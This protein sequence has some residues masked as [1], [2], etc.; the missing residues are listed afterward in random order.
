MPIRL[1]TDG[2]SDPNAGG[3]LASGQA[4][5][6]G[7]L[8]KASNQASTPGLDDTRISI[9][10]G[11]LSL[12]F[13]PGTTPPWVSPM[14]TGRS[15]NPPSP[16]CLDGKKY[17]SSGERSYPSSSLD[18]VSHISP[19]DRSSNGGEAHATSNVSATAET[20]AE[21]TKSS[22]WNPKVDSD[23]SNGSSRPYT[24]STV[25]NETNR[26]PRRRRLLSTT[27]H[28]TWVSSLRPQP[29]LEYATLPVWAAALLVASAF[30]VTGLVWGRLIYFASMGH[31]QDEVWKHHCV[32]PT[33]P[34]LYGLTYRDYR[35]A[36]TCHTVRFQRGDEYVFNKV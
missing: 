24:V 1:F 30:V 13:L 35:P 33:F 27:R 36:C 31:C 20:R 28:A 4:S 3:A 26:T 15:C 22:L 23:R 18:G 9:G 34:V 12:Y 19:R 2:V 8:E 7:K 21:P 10:D 32:Q 16:L 5:A 6:K 25:G 14:G 17:V 29:G 11:P